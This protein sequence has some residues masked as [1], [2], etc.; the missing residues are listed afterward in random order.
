MTYTLG[1]GLPDSVTPERIKRVLRLANSQ[2]RE[3]RGL[4]D[5]D[6]SPD[7]IRTAQDDDFFR[8]IQSLLR[9][10]EGRKAYERVQG[11]FENAKKKRAGRA[12][13]LGKLIDDC[14]GRLPISE[15]NDRCSIDELYG[16]YGAVKPALGQASVCE[17][18]AALM[19]A[20]SVR[21]G[22][23][24][25][26]VRAL[27]AC[28]EIAPYLEE[29]RVNLVQVDEPN[30]EDEAVALVR[31]LKERVAE[32]DATNLKQ[33]AIDQIVNDAHRLREITRAQYVA[34]E[35]VRSQY[36]AW[37]EQH[38]TAIAETVRLKD[39]LSR[40]DEFV[41]DPE[42]TADCLKTALGYFE[43]ALK[44]EAHVG[45]LNQK[46]E[47]AELEL[48]FVREAA[49]AQE[50]AQVKRNF[51]DLFAKIDAAFP[52]RPAE[53]AETQPPQ[54]EDR[55]P[56][57]AMDHAADESG[58]E[59]EP[60]S[61]PP[62]DVVAPTQPLL[63][64]GEVRERPDEEVAD[65]E[66][67]TPLETADNVTVGEIEHE[68]ATAIGRRHFWTAY[69]LALACE[70]ALPGKEA[71][72]L[73]ACNY[74]TDK[75]PSFISG[76]SP[77]A[78]GLWHHAESAFKGALEPSVQ[79][80]YAA[81]T[82]SAA[83]APALEAP[84]GSVA[85][86]LSKLEP[87]L[88]E[89]PSLQAL[90]KT[91]ADVSM[92]GVFL[93]VE[94]L[95]DRSSLEEWSQREMALRK[96]TDEWAERARH[97]TIRFHAATRVWQRMFDDWEDK[98]RV[99]IGRLFRLLKEP[100]DK[101]DVALISKIGA[102]WR[103][104]LEKEIDRV[105]REIRSTA[106]TKKLEGPARRD[107]RTR[108]EESLNIAERWKRLI[109][110]RPG[111]RPAFH[112]EQAALLRDAV[113]VNAEEA[114]KEIDRLKTS[115][116][117]A[118]K[119]LIRQYTALFDDGESDAPASQVSLSDL[120]NG[121]LLGCPAVHFDHE[122]KPS[123]LPVVLDTL[124]NFSRGDDPDFGK[125]AVERAKAGELRSAEATIDFG[126]R[127][128][129]LDVNGA[130]DIRSLV[131]EE[132]TRLHQELQ[133]QIKRMR[134][135]L[136]A[137][138]ARGIL[139]LETFDEFRD[140]LSSD[141]EFTIDEFAP[142]YNS[143]EEV[144]KDLSNIESQ[145]SGKL[146]R[147]LL[148]LLE[149]SDVKLLDDDKKR[150]E[151]A[152]QEQSFHVAEAYIEQ[153]QHGEALPPQANLTTNRAFDR[154]FPT[155][156][157]EYVDL[158]RDYPD[159]FTRIRQ[160]FKTGERVGP[161]H[162]ESLSEDAR[163]DASRFLDAWSVLREGR[164]TREPL[165]SLASELGL[166]KV[167]ARLDGTAMSTGEPVY[168]LST[169]PRADRRVA[170]LPDFGSRAKGEYRVLQIRGRKTAAPI[171]HELQEGSPGGIPP[172]LVLFLDVLDVSE[173]CDLARRLKGG[174]AY[175]A[176]AVL[177]EALAVFL[178][179]YRP[180]ER[181]SAFFDCASAFSTAQPFDPDAVEVPPEMFFGRDAERDAVRATSGAEKMTHLVY[182][183]RRLGKTALLA[184]VARESSKD[185]FI[186]LVNLKGSGI[187]DNRPAGD[188]WKEVADSLSKRE[189][190]DAKTVR[191]DTIAR[192]V[193]RW[194]ED[195]SKPGR[196]ILLL[197]DEADSFLEADGR[198]QYQVLEQIKRLMEETERR[199][200][201]V[202][203]G[204]HNVQRTARVS[205]TPFAHLGEPV[206]IGPMLPRKGH[207]EIQDLI[208]VPLETLGYRFSST[209]SVIRIAAETNYYP[210]LAQQFC[211]EL[212]RDLRENPEVHDDLSGPPYWISKETVNRV[213][214]SRETRD[215]IRNLFSWTIQLDPRFEFLT[216]LIARQ[217]FDNGSIQLPSIPIDR[218]R[219]EAMKEWP[220]GF[221]SD[222]SF[223]AFQVLLEE[224]VGLGILREAGDETYAIRTRNLR[225]LLG[226]D[227][228]IGRRFADAKSKPPHTTFDPAQFRNSLDNGIPSS[229][230]SDQE[231]QLC[232]GGNAVGLV[233]GT[234]LA[235]LHQVRES[236]EVA[237][238]AGE[239]IRL[240][241][242]APDSARR[243]L[244]EI[245]RA[246]QP[247]T[248][249]VLVDARDVPDLNWIGEILDFVAGLD[250]RN[251]V[252]RPV[253]LCGPAA[254]WAW[255]NGRPTA[256]PNVEIREIWLG[257]CAKNFTH[258]WLRDR[259]APAY[260]DLGKTEP[261]AD[262][263][264]PVVAGTAEKRGLETIRDAV[265]AVLASDDFVSDVL[266]NPEIKAVLSL[267]SNFSD[268]PMTGDLV[269]EF[270][271]EGSQ[272]LSPE[273]AMRVFDW[274]NRLGLLHREGGGY[275]LDSTYARG[276]A[277][278][279]AA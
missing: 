176:T 140:K 225:M 117:S 148:Q 120:L 221:E 222:C 269:S 192:G 246:R 155:F 270:L 253:L 59:P 45:D 162:A 88:Y 92:K 152:I 181:L 145:R 122:Y 29:V 101:V 54:G 77:I 52:R 183:G 213:L 79:N 94:M 245:V 259:E 27:D 67:E 188:L 236:L 232:S 118:A 194:L 205:N 229:L 86:L 230:T 78:D 31:N 262:P 13:F 32:L 204:L 25:F 189:I 242:E 240:R 93:S 266:V 206:S 139:P 208:R 190:V 265:D 14:I 218:I 244:G 26:I 34:L 143:F 73:V 19:W 44:V 15:L 216:Y 133:D 2:I 250:A 33:A 264:W 186:S 251:R 42:M 277:R 161:V 111:S 116:A 96:D 141:D 87:H 3:F 257:P 248:H 123:E 125:A 69:H 207:D 255:L 16:V 260:R 195:Q 157:T 243:S 126:E 150:I 91:A 4:L 5:G 83:L 271:R 191:P 169:E 35:R 129:F 276:L 210:A 275:R 274:G 239:G 6:A 30:G 138:Y 267:F 100:A 76:L 40:L 95:R 68:I 167:E 81:L 112:E 102:H 137:A 228:E 38:S 10:S 49:L 119:D 109:E 121:G 12:Y 160:A 214:D 185:V 107:L 233:F 202:F 165:C 66:G 103:H 254:S 18:F 261:S 90:V 36:Q 198:Q 22:R 72:A 256:R 200:K 211:K 41:T 164:I 61:E 217:S 263:L 238:R 65:N 105:D 187:G 227:A 7:W 124:M 24:D 82:A 46:L 177:D 172:N 237:G 70:Q 178:A 171:I 17:D 158:K 128:G 48:D 85:Q 58:P 135:R 74:V 21:S 203:A 53:D 104:N 154:F 132:R 9:T 110:E 56:A 252:I 108:V 156:V 215:R 127:T 197:I 136:D 278:V 182:G 8:R 220:A 63:E 159:C 174:G 39:S 64:E 60:E 175:P 130:D 89:T 163:E 20:H 1:N 168:I 47:R 113:R 51:A 223:A 273:D 80:S 209:D 241:E 247:G 180:G 23:S 199:F 147:E 201:V 279:F 11:T 268:E 84:G 166:K 219:E 249:I 114:L 184:N 134:D 50:Q 99:S 234:H 231:K 153:L 224:M 71:V 146:R 131:Q 106:T 212:L 37:R 28:P 55:E 75:H 98:G 258:T 149:S 193:K 173:R 62:A 196:R 142:I 151:E 235:G 226:N 97:S 43:E 179:E 57:T 272:D 144:G 170:Q 115:L